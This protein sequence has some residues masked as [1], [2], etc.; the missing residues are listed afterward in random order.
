[1]DFREVGSDNTSISIDSLAGS[2]KQ[3]GYISGFV[4]QERSGISEEIDLSS[5]KLPKLLPQRDTL[6]KSEDLTSVVERSSQNA[7]SSAFHLTSAYHRSTGHNYG[8]FNNTNRNGVFGETRGPFSLAQWQEVELQALIYRYIISGVRVP[9]ELLHPIRK[10]LNSAGFSSF[11]RGL[12]KTKTSKAIAWE[13]DNNIQEW[14]LMF[15]SL[16][17]EGLSSIFEQ[18]DYPLMGMVMAITGFFV[19]I[20]EIVLKARTE[21]VTVEWKSSFP[22]FYS[23]YPNYKLFG[24]TILYFGLVAAI[25]QCFHSS[26]GYYYACKKME[27][28]IR[29]TITMF[30]FCICLIISRIMKKY[31]NVPPS[32]TEDSCT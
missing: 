1:M 7:S 30:L 16:V 4:K 28:P 11:S 13:F 23:H 3:D 19:C 15:T 8:N 25:W 29:M 21:R 6:L 12:L 14:L 26:L 18:L 10:G 9:P 22:W 20:V 27:N 24:S 31:S 2:D 5:F 32:W 17:L